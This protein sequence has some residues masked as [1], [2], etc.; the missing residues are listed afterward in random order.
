VDK[1]ELGNVL[2]EKIKKKINIHHEQGFAQ[3]MGKGFEFILFN[4]QENW[5]VW[6]SFI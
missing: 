6:C 1:K 3:S 2:I 5:F 4:R